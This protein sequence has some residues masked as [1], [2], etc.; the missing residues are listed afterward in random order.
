MYARNTIAKRRA[1]GWA[2]R[3]RYYRRLFELVRPKE[4]KDEDAQK[5]AVANE[6]Y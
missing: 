3:R 4:L 5:I 1:P 6:K 2:D